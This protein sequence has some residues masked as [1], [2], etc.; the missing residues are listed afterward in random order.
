MQVHLGNHHYKVATT[1]AGRK[2]LAKRTV[3]G[4]CRKRGK[5]LR[6]GHVK[7]RPKQNLSLGARGF[8]KS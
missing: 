4:V 8:L 2:L 6:P 7:P 3:H 5:S 1:G